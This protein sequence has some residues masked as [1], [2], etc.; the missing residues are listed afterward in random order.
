M[1]YNMRPYNQILS[2]YQVPAIQSINTHHLIRHLQ[3]IQLISPNVAPVQCL[4][5]HSVPPLDLPSSALP[6]PAMSRPQSGTQNFQKNSIPSDPYSC[7]FLAQL[8]GSFEKKTSQVEMIQVELV[9]DG[10]FQYGLVHRKRASGE[11]APKQLIKEEDTRFT[12]CSGDGFV[13]AVMVKGRIMRQSVTWYANDRSEIVWC[14]TGDVTFKLVTLTPEQ[15]RRNS[16]A[17]IFSG[18]S[19]MSYSN[20]SQCETT[21]DVRMQI[22]PEL[23]MRS[24]QCEYPPRR[25]TKESSNGSPSSSFESRTSSPILPDRRL[26]NDELFEHFRKYCLNYPSLQQRIIQWGITRTPNSRVGDKEISAL[27]GGRVWVSATLGQ[28]STTRDGDYWQEI[29]NNYKGA[30]QQDEPGVF[31]QPPAQPN[32]P[33]IQHRLRRSQNGLWMIDEHNV[34]ED[35]WDS[36]AKELP[37]GKWVDVKDSRMSYNIKIIPMESIL[38]TIKDQLTDFEDI[39]RSIDFLFNSC[40][41]KKLNTKLKARN[42]KHNI[43]NLKLKLG[44]QYALSFAV[45]VSE[46]AD[47]IASSRDDFHEEI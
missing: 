41:Q 23:C 37:G 25:V 24:E 18:V 12:L 36:C 8:E 40:N 32:E 43:S 42:L 4:E 30:Y 39:Q 31:L 44:K 47:S 26:S 19:Q 28:P 46:M 38:C 7:N 21:A 10:D 17:S 22:R 1:T 3:S 5:G 15:S 6:A 14:R 20:G 34:E 35:V 9:S 33:G 2:H 13:L 29:L 45:R 16:L 11:L 27:A